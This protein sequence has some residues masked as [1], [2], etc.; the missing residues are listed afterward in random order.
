MLVAFTCYASNLAKPYA[1]TRGEFLS[2]QLQIQL[3][4]LALIRW[5][6]GQFET[7]IGVEVDEKSNTINVQIA[8]LTTMTDEQK[9]KYKEDIIES[10]K[11]RCKQYDWAKDLSIN[12]H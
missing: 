10:V 5:N 7:G 4:N 8:Y 6:I 2:M 11:K 3:N 12:V 9:Q 1:L